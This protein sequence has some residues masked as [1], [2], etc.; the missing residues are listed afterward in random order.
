MEIQELRIDEIKIDF[1]TYAYRD[2]LNEETVKGQ[3]ELFKW[4]L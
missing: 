4:K 2:E 1:E 3:L